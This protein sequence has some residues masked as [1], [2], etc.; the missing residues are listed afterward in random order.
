MNEPEAFPLKDYRPV[1]ELV[2]P[3]HRVEKPSYPVID[4]HTHFG[5]KHRNEFFE[6]RYCAKMACAQ[7]QEK[8]VCRAVDLSIFPGLPYD[9]KRKKTKRINGFLYR[10]APIDFSSLGKPD[11]E[12]DIRRQFAQFDREGIYGIK[13]WKNLTLQM[14]VGG[15][16]VSL[17]DPRL[18]VVWE[19]AAARGWPVTV[20]AADPPAFFKEPDGRNERMEELLAMPKWRYAKEPGLSFQGLM[21]QQ[22][23]LLQENKKTLFIIAH[24]GSWPSNLQQVGR[25]MAQYHN[26]YVDTAA[27]LSELGRQPYT[28]ASFFERHQDRILFGT[29][30]FAGERDCYGTWYRFLETR[31]EYFPHNPQNPSWGGRWNIYGIQLG[32]EVLEKVYYKNAAKLLKIGGKEDWHVRQ[33]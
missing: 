17:A 25:W 15:K 2:V 14:K 30:Y 31:D 33:E 3:A 26:L 5:A 22:E 1:S 19:E 23:R 13:I 28:S 11:F 10:F 6:K 16:H 29:D 27:C 20:H 24:M 8:G 32:K 7:L 9:R 21:E 12:Q 18:C 4:M